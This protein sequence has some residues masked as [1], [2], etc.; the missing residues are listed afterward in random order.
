MLPTEFARVTSDPTNESY[1]S[2]FVG[3]ATWDRVH[4]HLLGA[5]NVPTA[6]GVTGD[7][8]SDPYVL[9]ELVPSSAGE[10]AAT[11]E[12]AAS[13]VA[14]EKTLGT[15]KSR[16]VADAVNPDWDVIDVLL[17]KR[18]VS[19]TLRVAVVDK[20]GG[21]FSG[22]ADDVLLDTTVE[23]PAAH[24]TAWTSHTLSFSNG[25][26]LSFRC[27]TSA[28]EDKIVSKADVAAFPLEEVVLDP[29]SPV[30]GALQ[31]RVEEANTK[32]VFW[33]LG[34]NDVFMHP[35]LGKLF[36]SMGFDIYILNYLNTGICRR[37]GRMESGNPML[38]SHVGPG[39]SFD[40]VNAEVDAALAHIAG[41]GKQYAKMLCY[42]HST[43]GTI[44]LN[45]LLEA[46]AKGVTAPF[47]GYALN[48]P[49]MDWGWVGGDVAEA[50]LEHAVTKLVSWGVKD[51]D[52]TV[53]QGLLG[54]PNTW[55]FKLW[56]QVEYDPTAKPLYRTPLTAGFVKACTD[57][58]E[59]VDA[60][61]KDAKQPP[62][63]DKPFLVMTS[64]GDDVLVA[65][66]T[67]SSAEKIGPRRTVIEMSNGRHDVMLSSEP[68]VVNAALQY[69]RA[70]MEQADFE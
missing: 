26:T 55:C 8:P 44:M 15:F 42:A 24:S 13:R 11:D 45:W 60:C 21:I 53:P 31:T 57:V 54:K 69:L 16:A 37:L 18:A 41:A 4:F 65:E 33:V 61:Y 23:L 47:D 39:A 62:I 52:W 14:F 40:A 50:V 9:A 59:R 7:W 67:V 12:Q 30:G 36:A 48:S 49:N 3:D 68:P 56:S 38:N 10:P 20:D 66:E 63:T 28:A 58:Y 46:R 2:G 22:G 43:G 34:R 1:T 17:Y 64:R 51:S 29:S 70:W 27:R 6:D 5:R 19:Y 32:A 35:H 25:G